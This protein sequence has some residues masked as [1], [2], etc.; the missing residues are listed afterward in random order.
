MEIERLQWV[1]GDLVKAASV[2]D[3]TG[4]TKDHRPTEDF[5]YCVPDGCWLGLVD[6]FLSTKGST[7]NRS[8]YFVMQGVL[9]VPDNLV[10]SFRC[11]LVLGPGAIL[12]GRFINNEPFDQ[13]MF[14]VVTG[15]LARTDETDYR[16]IVWPT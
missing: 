16:K 8:S 3:V 12:S 15:Y 4:K 7:I 6:V 13:H 14:A 9:S 11:P 10:A 5:P 1:C 2:L